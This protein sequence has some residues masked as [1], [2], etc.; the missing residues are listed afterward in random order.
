MKSSLLLD[1]PAGLRVEDL[2]VIQNQIRATLVSSH[3]TSLCPQCGGRSR[4][5]HS[6]YIRTIADLSCMGH[7]V[8]LLLHVRK[9]FCESDTCKVAI[10]TERFPNF[11]QSSARKTNRLLQ[12]LRELGL[13]LGGRATE[14]IAPHLGI[15][16]SDTTVLRH[17][18]TLP[19]SPVS[20]VTV[21]GV[22]DFAFRRG[23]RY[24]TILV[25]L[26]RHQVIDLLPDRSQITFALW[27]KNHQEV[28]V[29]SRDRGGD[30]AAGAT[31]GVPQARQIADRFHLL[32]NA[33]AVL[34]RVLTR[35]QSFLNQASSH[36]SSDTAPSRHRSQSITEQ[37]NQQTR[38]E[39]RLETY[40]HVIALFHQGMSSCQIVRETGLAR[41]TV[42]SYIRAETFPEQAPRPRPRQID[43]YV[44]FL[45]EQW[46]A[47]EHNA[48]ALWRV[49]G[50]QGFEGGEEQVR[51]ILN[52]WRAAPH[53]QGRS[54]DQDTGIAHK[55]KRH[56]S[57]RSTRWLLSKGVQARSPDEN[58]YIT[59]LQ[60]SCPEITRANEILQQFHE[61][62]LAQDLLRF[63]LW[64][65][66]CEQCEIPELVGFA[67]GIR[68]DEQAV[69]ASM[70]MKWS[71]GQVEGQVNRVK[72]IKRQMYGRASF[73]L[74]RQRVLGESP[75]AA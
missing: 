15:Q 74:L 44:P 32:V 51:R 27:L 59:L 5:V 61:I 39:K 37:T 31:L 19:E 12:E 24:G 40:T 53:K 36:V 34:E 1:L 68:R 11:L 14:R 3:V 49:I 23:Q 26:E 52:S 55:E 54:F 62:L 22:D 69:Q 4:R 66:Q 43:P 25:D 45:Q 35:H 72:M 56:Y 8:I 42:L 71:Q 20:P 67:L 33:G 64:L 41:G 13:S 73:P 9:F 6:R 10:F 63:S 46:N 2:V 38:R 28:Q 47:G 48:R 7:P 65:L 18:T 29:I 60:Q 30:Y 50:H 21:L 58:T 75:A 16:V 70:E 57:S 17:L